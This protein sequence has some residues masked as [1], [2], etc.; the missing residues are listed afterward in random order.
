MECMVALNGFWGQRRGV[1]Q[2]MNDM[3]S[4]FTYVQVADNTP[5]PVDEVR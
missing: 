5:I 1:L 4:R 3:R 2:G